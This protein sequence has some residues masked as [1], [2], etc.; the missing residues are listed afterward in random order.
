MKH[1]HSNP[2]SE[3]LSSLECLYRLHNIYTSYPGSYFDLNSEQSN[4]P[5]FVIEIPE[6]DEINVYQMMAE[7]L[8]DK[9]NDGFSI[10]YILN[11]EGEHSRQI[12]S[13][14][15]ARLAYY[16]GVSNPLI[17]ALDCA[18]RGDDKVG[19][20][21]STDNAKLN[22]GLSE[23]LLALYLNKRNEIY[24]NTS[25]KL[26]HQLL[27]TSNNNPRKT[28]LQKELEEIDYMQSSVDYHIEKLNDRGITPLTLPEIQILVN[29]ASYKAISKL[30]SLS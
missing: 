12:Y 11:H 21:A 13:F 22:N 14:G 9:F 25:Y 26:Y 19:I 20:F 1:R 2:E 5:Y 10:K 18:L 28:I 15:F 3:H 7:K 30:E 27:K 24:K 17:P 16:F 29:L 6:L 8:S 23:K 4:T